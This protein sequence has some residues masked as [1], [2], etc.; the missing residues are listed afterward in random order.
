MGSHVPHTCNAPPP[1]IPTFYLLPFPFLFIFCIFLKRYAS[2]QACIVHTLFLPLHI[3]HSSALYSNM[4]RS[5]KFHFLVWAHRVLL[6]FQG[7]GWVG[8]IPFLFHLEFWTNSLCW[9]FSKNMDGLVH[10]NN[11]SIPFTFSILN[12]P[13]GVGSPRIWVGG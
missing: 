4:I 5:A 2:S 10:F 1:C 3:G 12:S 8:S 6:V 9:W 11:M 13:C 7:Y